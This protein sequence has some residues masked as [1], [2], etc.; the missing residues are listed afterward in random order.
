[1]VLSSRAVRYRRFDRP[2]TVRRYLSSQSLFVEH[3]PETL[4]DPARTAFGITEA[5]RSFDTVLMGRSTYEVALPHGITSPYSHLNQIVFSTTM[6]NTLDERVR[7]EASDPAQVVDELKAQPGLGIWLCGGGQLAGA[8]LEQIDVLV[9]KR[10][11]LILGAGRP[12]IS[13]AYAPHH[14]DLVGRTPVGSVTVET[15]HRK[16]T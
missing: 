4:P 13:G 5:G 12:M 9:I 3:L 16:R 2:D 11:P 14:F 8:L 1:M 10:Q 15:Y 7:L 6:P